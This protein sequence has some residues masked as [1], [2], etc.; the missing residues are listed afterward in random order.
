MY[1]CAALGTM[2]SCPDAQNKHMYARPVPLRHQIM[3]S[4]HQPIGK[5][6][7]EAS[8]GQAKPELKNSVVVSEHCLDFY[9]VRPSLLQRSRILSSSL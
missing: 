1:Y 5:S 2:K 8:F 6:I 9:F 3:C 7:N 4:D